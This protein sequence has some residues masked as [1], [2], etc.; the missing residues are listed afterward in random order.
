MKTYKILSNVI[1]SATAIMISG[2]MA[3]PTIVSAKS[4]LSTTTITNTYSPLNKWSISCGAD[5]GSIRYKRSEDVWTFKQS[6]NYC[7]GGF[8]KQR[9]ELTSDSVSPRLKKSYLFESNITF[10]S[11]SNEPFSIFQLHDGRDGCAPPASILVNENGNIFITSDVK[12]GPGENCIRG[13]LGN[14]SKDIVKRD[15][16]EQNFRVLFDFDGQGG[17]VVSVWLDGK[18]QITDKYIPVK[19]AYTSSKY[20][21]KHG[22][23]SKNV[24]N[25]VMTSKNKKVS[26]VSYY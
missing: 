4:E 16:T 14:V 7:S 25:Y 10:S 11:Q 5:N 15:G 18:L 3:E 22:V 24:F 20:Y 6:K 1:I 26:E 8:F 17:F 23:Y 12:T 13:T 2:C 19:E 9:S 21:F